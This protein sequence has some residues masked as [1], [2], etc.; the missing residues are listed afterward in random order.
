MLV[1]N[2]C[3]Y[4]SMLGRNPAPAC[5]RDLSPP[6]TFY[7]FSCCP[8]HT[9]ARCKCH[10]QSQLVTV[11]VLRKPG[12][13]CVWHCP[14]GHRRNM[15]GRWRH[16]VRSPLMCRACIQRPTL[17]AFASEPACLRQEAWAISIDTVLP[18]RHILRRFIIFI[19]LPCFTAS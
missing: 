16:D 5:S 6:L 15:Y 19:T 10:L 1:Q 14:R 11:S 8:V 4:R 17:C 2:T 9:S 12:L 13:S 7:S 3:L 18:G